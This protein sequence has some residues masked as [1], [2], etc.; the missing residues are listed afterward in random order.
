MTIINFKVDEE[1]KRKIEEITRTKG[2][3]SISAFIREAIDDKMNLQKIVDDFKNKNPPL[4][5]EKIE[6]P[7]F[8]PDGKYLGI[9][10]NT[11]VVIEDSLQDAMKKLFEK[12]PEA[13]A[14]II[15]KGKE[16]EQF[17]TLFSLFSTENTK[18]FQQAEIA[19]RFFPILEFFITL[20]GDKKSLLGLVDTGASIMALDR[21]F[22]ENFE[23]KPIRK[24]KILTANGIIEAPIYKSM[25]Q[26]ENLS[27]ELEFTS[28]E[29][30]GLPIQA[31]IGK[32]F[33]DEFNVLFLGG[34]KLFCIQN[35]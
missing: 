16:M 32:N 15:R 7:E 21:T 27:Y 4:D 25:F 3:K 24:S 18:C 33:I 22:I 17:E 23:L 20:K 11:I 6:I 19:K 34:E 5:M 1:K 8:I 12:F 9:S 28:S 26:Y 31:L 30:S 29:I 2:Y 13:S 10:R 35:L 14:G